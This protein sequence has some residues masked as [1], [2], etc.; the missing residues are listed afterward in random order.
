[1]PGTRLA[2]SES[3]SVQGAAPWGKPRLRQEL[4]GSWRADLR[5]AGCCPPHTW[6]P[7]SSGSCT[8][9]P[10]AKGQLGVGGKLERK[11]EELTLLLW[12]DPETESFSPHT[13]TCCWAPQRTDKA[14]RDRVRKLRNAKK[15]RTSL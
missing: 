7:L 12:L 3:S 15:T 1:M 11:A 13:P 2:H 14:S 6:I 4:G 8:A 9:G 5:L 10:E